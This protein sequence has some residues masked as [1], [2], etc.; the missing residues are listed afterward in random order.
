MYDDQNI[1]EKLLKGCLEKQPKSQRALVDRYSGYLFATCKRYLNDEELARDL[2]QESLIKIFKNLDKFD[3]QKG[4]FKSW[5]TTITIRLCLSKLQKNKMTIVSLNEEL[6]TEANLIDSSQLDHL[7]TRY[8]IEMISELPDGYREVFNM[9]A[10]DG[11]SHAEIAEYLNITTD[12]SRTRLLRAR[13]KLKIRIEK[14]NN[15]EIWVKSI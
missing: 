5:I 6:D 15:E 13:K 8:L 1:N 4:S 3:K 9:F 11:Y 10:I 2:L 7:D 12:V 14:L